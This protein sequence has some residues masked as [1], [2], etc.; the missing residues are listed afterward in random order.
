MRVMTQAV[1]TDLIRWHYLWYVA[2]ALVFMIAAIASHHLWFL[3][4]LHVFSGLLWTGIDLFMGF[5]L[6]PILRVVELP[7]RKAVLLRLTPRTL[8]LMPTLAIV[9]GTTG[10]YLAED[11]GFTAMSWPP[12][13]W[14]VASLVLVFLMTIQGIG[15]LLPTNF[16][17]CLELQKDNPDNAR[18]ASLTNSYFFAVALQGVMQIVT[19]IIMARFATGI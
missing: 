18:I 8:F 12:Y 1:P 7:A 13:A 4:F 16:R 15:Y 6:G 17:V 19:I 14:V 9:T 2:L 5:V 10:W 11:M 3:N